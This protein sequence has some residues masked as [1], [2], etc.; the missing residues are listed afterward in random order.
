MLGTG[1][2]RKPGL[3]VRKQTNKHWHWDKAFCTWKNVVYVNPPSTWSDTNTFVSS[4]HF[5]RGLRLFR[6]YYKVQKMTSSWGAAQLCLG[7][8]NCGCLLPSRCP[9]DI[10]SVD[11]M[12]SRYVYS[13]EIVFA[14]ARKGKKLPGKVRQILCLVSCKHFQNFNKIAFGKQT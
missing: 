4:H 10:L 6:L 5:S 7:G 14:P 8:S 3:R 1:L 11:H 12:R 9:L 2:G 13:E